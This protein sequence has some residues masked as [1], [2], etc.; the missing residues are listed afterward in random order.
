MEYVNGISL[1]KSEKLTSKGYDIEEIGLKLADNYIKQ[2]LDDG[3]FHA[4]PHQDNIFIYEG[5]IV[6]LDLGMMGRISSRNR[7]ILNDAVKA[8]VRNNTGE[9]EHLLLSISTTKGQINHAKLRSEIKMLLDKNAGEDIK[10][11]DIKQFLNS[12][13]TLL[14][15][16]N[17]ILDKNIT[18]LMRGICVIEGTL[19]DLAPNINL[20]TVLTNRIKEKSI[21]DV[22][23]K[24]AML[25]TGRN[26]LNGAEAISVL[27]NELLNL[28]R[29]LNSGD[30]K[31]DIEMANSAKQ[32]H[33]LEK[34]LHQLIIGFLDAAVL[35]G[36]SMIKNDVLRWI[37]LGFAIVFS[38]WLFI[39]MIKD[40]FR[41]GY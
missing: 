1:N 40:H 10:N 31:I 27:P 12:V 17:I 29:D 18:L 19:Q 22:F 38:M 6:Y 24:E 21:K 5:K 36:A 32:I 30:T 8:I 20:I 3:F 15:K 23:S 26:V 37:Y 33:K 16:N 35:L 9:L 4:D 13:S 7:K 34:M 14:R 2:A 28:V 41:K 11:I 25:N 39:E